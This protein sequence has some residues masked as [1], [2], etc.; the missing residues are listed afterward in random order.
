MQSQQSGACPSS[1]APSSAPIVAYNANNQVAGVYAPNSTQASPSPYTYDQAG[2]VTAD[3]TGT[4]NQ[5]LYD[6]EGRVCAVQSQTADGS[7][8]M[9]GYVYDADGNRVAKGTITSWSC[10]PS[11]NGLTAAGNETDYVLGPG[12]E[13][14]TELTQNAGGAMQWQ[15]TYVY[16]GSALIATY[17]SEPN[18]AYSSTNNTVPQTIALPSFRLTDWLGTMR[19][20][21]DAYGVA[22]GT[23]AGLPYG[24]GQSCS[25][26][27]PDSHYFTG[28]Q[29]D[30]ES[31]NDYFGARYYGSSMGRF[32]SP[33][34]SAK[35]EP[36]PYAK[37]G[38]PQS[39]NLYGYMLDNPLAGVDP[40]GHAPAHHLNPCGKYE[41]RSKCAELM[42]QQ[43]S[44]GPFLAK[45]PGKYMGK[46]CGSGQCVDFVKA[47]TDVPRQT[48]DWVPGAKVETKTPGGAAIATFGPNGKYENKVGQSHAAELVSVAPNGKSAVIRDQ[49]KGQQVNTRTIYDR[50]G[51][52]LPVNDLS[53]FR[54]IMRRED[55]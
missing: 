12:G 49:W 50:G 33:D 51:K 2:D 36:V 42:A 20:A 54:V 4:G 10:D 45:D 40:D 15:R 37:M 8:V 17:E 48:K 5:Y 31:G 21:T 1:S 44:D 35:V 27:I 23:C 55:Q 38:D 39:L 43:Q 16:A 6:A 3:T 52:G 14:V 28:K 11:V 29:R 13:Q 24:D 26:A 9:T 18:P 22:Q 47:D 34:W 32:L 7:W 30:P 19:A 25:G 46:T 53:R 41:N